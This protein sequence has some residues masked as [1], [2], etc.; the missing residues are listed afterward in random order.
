ML[1]KQIKNKKKYLDNNYLY[2]GEAEE[3]MYCCSCN[4][5][6]NIYDYNVKLV[7]NKKGKFDEIITCPNSS[8][9]GGTD[10]W[11]TP[12]VA[13]G[14]LEDILLNKELEKSEKMIYEFIVSILKIICENKDE[15]TI[16][17]LLNT[18]NK[19]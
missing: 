3:I 15:N 9:V 2:G 7:L 18:F 12:Y 6:F 16:N 5:P 14:I 13:L 1:Y 10:Y 19:F 8:C 11:V 4:I 17:K